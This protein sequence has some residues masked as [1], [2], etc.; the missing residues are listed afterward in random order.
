MG[1]FCGSV[2]LA[3]CE[4][5]KD[6]P[7]LFFITGIVQSAKVILIMNGLYALE[8]SFLHVAHSGF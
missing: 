7:F 8:T 2:R 4:P 3:D 1:N 5:N 6:Y